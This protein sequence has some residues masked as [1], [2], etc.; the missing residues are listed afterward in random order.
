MK[1]IYLVRH[2]ET[3]ENKNKVLQ[4]QSHGTLSSQGIEQ[5]QRLAER[6]KS[7]KLDIIYSSDLERARH[8]TEQIARHHVC[9]IEYLPELRERAGGVYEGRPYSEF[10]TS[11][12]QA[13]VP[14][15]K[16]T[17]E[18]GES[19]EEVVLRC[20]TV[21]ER[22]VTSPHSKTL[23]VSHGV[24]NRCIISI[25]TKTPVRELLQ[26]EQG[27][28]CVN[29]FELSAEGEVLQV[30]LNCMQHLADRGSSLGVTE[31]YN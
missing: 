8:T 6:L 4:G 14:P 29:T 1:T 2:G 7:H 16:F 9:P 24:A 19:V 28:T 12:A 15:E 26:L 30:T 31:L 10:T 25:L 11:R 20:R 13:E 22:I 23:M 27:N 18:G 17:V 3:N 21:I 5:A